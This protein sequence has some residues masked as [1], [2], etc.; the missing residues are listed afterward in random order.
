[1]QTGCKIFLNNLNVIQKKVWELIQ[2]FPMPTDSYLFY[3]DDR[4]VPGS[5]RF[6]QIP[7]LQQELK[8]L[9]MFDY[10]INTGIVIAFERGL[11]IHQD[12]GD[13]IYS[14]L[15]PIKNTT[16]TYTVFYKTNSQ[17]YKVTL[18]SGTSLWRYHPEHCEEIQRFESTE[19][20]L[21]NVKTP[22]NVVNHSLEQPRV[23]ITL[24]LSPEFIFN[25]QTL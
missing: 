1:M 14:L 19:P 23:L 9:G 8:R 18:D 6:R 4:T 16:N 21:I 11:S 24:R 20:I 5:D 12:N 2:E 17:P 7:E 3:A 10:W 25:T 22:H 15:I 13:P